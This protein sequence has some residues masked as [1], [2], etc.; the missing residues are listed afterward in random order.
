MSVLGIFGL[1]WLLDVLGGSGHSQP[2]VKELVDS[3]WYEI[4]PEDQAGEEAKPGVHCIVRYGDDCSSV[5]W[6]HDVW[7]K[8]E[9]R[10]EL[11]EVT[12]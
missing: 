8:A 2:S 5:E 9:V 3:G 4:D 10:R 1:L 11:A 7:C 6:V 12:F